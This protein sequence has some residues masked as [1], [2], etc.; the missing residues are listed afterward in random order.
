LGGTVISGVVNPIINSV[1]FVL[2]W[3]SIYE[4]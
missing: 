2:F 1:K 4:I 3:M